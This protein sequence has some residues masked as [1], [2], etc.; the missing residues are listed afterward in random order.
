MKIAGIKDV[1]S[2]TL[3]QTG[4]KINLVGACFDALGK[5]IEMKVLSKYRD[6]IGIVEGPIKQEIKEEIKE[7][8]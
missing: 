6:N 3:G 5:L 4:T 8:S 1:W 2:K 7:E